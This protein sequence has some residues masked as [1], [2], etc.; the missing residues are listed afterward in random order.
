MALGFPHPLTEIGTRILLWRKARLALKADNL[1]AIC[2]SIA[3][4]WVNLDVS[5]HYR[6]PRH[7]TGIALFLLFIAFLP[8]RSE[9]QTFQDVSCDDCRI[10]PRNH[11]KFV[12]KLL[13]HLLKTPDHSVFYLSWKK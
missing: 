5:Q 12:S 6:P 11:I 8:S 3:R 2:E 10:I 13:S 7:V 4:K 9:T 1:T